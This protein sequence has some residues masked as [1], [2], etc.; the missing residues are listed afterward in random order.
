M[1]EGGVLLIVGA[2][3]GAVIV[4]CV[5]ESRDT[6]NAYRVH[7]AAIY[8]RAALSNLID[9]DVANVRH[10]LESIIALEEGE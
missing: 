5:C 1:I 10:C 4:M 8:A 6:A 3:L 9:G 7:S 2:V